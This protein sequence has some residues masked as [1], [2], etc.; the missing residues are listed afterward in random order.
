MAIDFKRE[1]LRLRAEAEL[2]SEERNKA[3]AGCMLAK[4]EC[5]ARQKTFLEVD[6]RFQR[7]MRASW[8]LDPDAK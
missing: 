6:E 8:A 4:A 2:L 7:L 3:Q 5:D 1:A